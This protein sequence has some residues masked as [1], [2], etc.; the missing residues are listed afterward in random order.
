MTGQP[1][2]APEHPQAAHRRR[3]YGD[4]GFV[5][6]A[7]LV[8]DLIRFNEDVKPS[9]SRTDMSGSR[10]GEPEVY[11]EWSYESHSAGD[12]VVLHEHRWPSLHSLATDP[13]RCEHY[14]PKETR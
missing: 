1:K 12:L 13:Y 2:P 8:A 3:H 7:C 9:S 14:A 6:V 5:P 11:T 4:A 10:T